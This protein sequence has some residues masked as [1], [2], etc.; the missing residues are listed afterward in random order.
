M[1]VLVVVLGA[2]VEFP[3]PEQ[4]AGHLMSSLVVRGEQLPV[5]VFQAAEPVEVLQHV[6]EPA[7]PAATEVPVA[8]PQQ[9]QLQV[10]LHL[11]LEGAV[12]EPTAALTIK[13][14]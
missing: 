10:D 5:P 7:E 9:E 13:T 11:E 4:L 1:V 14:D 3:Q 2:G 8:V 12:V 6:T